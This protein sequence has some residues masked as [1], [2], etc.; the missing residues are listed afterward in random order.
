MNLT[1][2]E[3]HFQSQNSF[4]SYIGV[5]LNVKRVSNILVKF[6]C[7]NSSNSLKSRPYVGEKYGC[8]DYSSCY[9]QHTDRTQKLHFTTHS[10]FSCKVLHFSLGYLLCGEISRLS[11][12][13]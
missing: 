7:L 1:H 12:L 6:N 11:P 10:P 9:L 13:L 4:L 3:D 2:D 5:C 8:L